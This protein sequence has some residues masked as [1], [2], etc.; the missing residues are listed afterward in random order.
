MIPKWAERLV[1]EALVYLEGQGYKP[2]VPTI[3]WRKGNSH[4]SSGR[5]IGKERIVVTAGKDR[6]DAKLVVLHELAHLVT[7]PEPQYWNIERAKK[8]GWMFPE[9]PTKPIVVRRI[10]HTD[11]FWDIA[12]QLYRWAKLPIRY[13]QR[14]EYAYK[15]GAQVAYRRM[16]PGQWPSRKVSQH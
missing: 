6:T 7:E 11:K 10:Y 4:C 9:E 14:R 13:C 12:W 2:P 5:A 8:Q 16:R 1:L 3:T 15:A